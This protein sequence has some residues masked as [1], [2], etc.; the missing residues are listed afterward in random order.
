M[1]SRRGIQ[2]HLW[3]AILLVLAVPLSCTTLPADSPSAMVTSPV[4]ALPPAWTPTPTDEMPV[5]TPPSPTAAS[6]LTL[7]SPW[8]F[9]EP[10]ADQIEEARAC[11]S[12]LMQSQPTSDA[13]V[14]PQTQGQGSFGRACDLAHEAYERAQQAG[15][16]QGPPQAGIE[17][18]EG[19][20]QANPAFLF[21]EDLFY[22]YLDSAPLAHEP[23]IA[24]QP[25]EAVDL[26][27]TW[28]GLGEP[29]K[30]SLRIDD[31][32]TSPKVDIL[33]FEGPPISDFLPQV[34][35]D[36]VQALGSALTDLVPIP[37]SNTFVNCTDNLPDWTVTLHFRGGA[38]LTLVTNGSNMLSLGG[39]WQVELDGAWYVQLSSA[40]ALA[41]YNLADAMKVPLGQP[42]G[43]FCAPVPVFTTVYGE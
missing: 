36:V 15:Y 9:P 30:Y 39:P 14:T 27:Y 28:G 16:S 1:S 5:V 10:S 32:D 18:F 43:M 13:A 11:P 41:I 31:A 33:D 34:E 37:S 17:A 19:A 35:A 12:I 4:I 25:I 3:M 26:R 38:V 22:P 6:T 40:F 24:S 7:P 42:A 23:P 20:I 29:V 21:H 8:P 2:L